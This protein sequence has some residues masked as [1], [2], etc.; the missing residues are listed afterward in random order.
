MHELSIATNIVNLIEEKRREH[1][2]EHVSKI[3]LKIGEFSSVVPEALE[4]GFSIASKDSVAENA[5]L[6]IQ[7]VPLVLR[8]NTCN[9]EFPSEPYI[10]VCPYC[11]SMDTDIVSGDELQ[12]ESIEV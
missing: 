5:E 9:K 12:I 1:N 11:E 7:T 8:C 4:F 6:V 3:I 10:F 2:F